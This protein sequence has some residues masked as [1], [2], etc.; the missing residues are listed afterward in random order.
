LHPILIVVFGLTGASAWLLDRVL[1][2]APPAADA[3]AN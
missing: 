2:G 3:P 1:V